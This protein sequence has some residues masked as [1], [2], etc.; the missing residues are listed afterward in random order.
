M[1][2]KGLEANRQYLFILVA[3]YILKGATPSFTIYNLPFTISPQC[4]QAA[5]DF[6]SF[7]NPH[8]SIIVLNFRNHVGTAKEWSYVSS[9]VNLAVL[10]KVENVAFPQGIVFFHIA[11]FQHVV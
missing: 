6:A 3:P 10:G 8:S 4:G 1:Q 5:S 9:E 7:R 11:C 2:L